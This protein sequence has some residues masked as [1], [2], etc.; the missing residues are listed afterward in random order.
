MKQPQNNEKEVLINGIN[1]I[2]KEIGIKSEKYNII[3]NIVSYY[4]LTIIAKLNTNFKDFL[5]NIWKE[6]KI[7]WT[8]WGVSSTACRI[9]NDQIAWKGSLRICNKE[10]LYFWSTIREIESSTIR[11]K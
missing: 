7:N 5:W 11:K 3:Q 6:K 1:L 8:T 9:F 2:L 10:Y 4:N